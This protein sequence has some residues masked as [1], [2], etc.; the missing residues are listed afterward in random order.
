M[1]R[2]TKVVI[3][4]AAVGA[5]ALGGAGYA[6][7]GGADDDATDTPITGSALDQASA[8]ALEHTGEGGSPRPRSA[9]RRATTRSRSPSTTARRSTSSSTRSSTSSSDEADD[10]SS[11]DDD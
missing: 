10:D 7:A 6:V 5:L 3:A 1:R 2:R 8:A 9:T 4:G 11:E